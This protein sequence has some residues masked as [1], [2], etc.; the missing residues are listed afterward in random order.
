MNINGFIYQPLFF[1][2]SCI[3]WIG[4]ILI[5][6]VG[7]LIPKK[8]LGDLGFAYFLWYGILRL[9]LEGLREPR[10]AFA[11]TYIMSSIWVF[12]A[13]ALIILNHTLFT[14]IRKYSFKSTI[15]NKKI[16]LKTDDQ[17]LYY[18]GR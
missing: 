3:N 14:R 15:K 12:I 6:F 11:T 4:L 10:F 8:K 2:E 18:L 7:E 5:F 1:Y 16:S 17:M 9:C 13:I